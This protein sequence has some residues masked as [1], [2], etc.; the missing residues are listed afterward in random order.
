[1]FVK[2]IK[3]AERAMFPIFRMNQ[4]APNQA[5]ISVVGTGFFIKPDG[6]FITVAHVFDNPGPQTSYQF[7]GYLPTSLH[8]PSIPIVE[9]ARDNVNDIYVGRINLPTPNYMKL[10]SEL[11]AI[12]RT[13]CISGY[14]LAAITVNAQG[15]LELSGV[16]RYFQPSFVLDHGISQIP[17]GNINRNHNGFLIRDFGLFGMSGGPVFDKTGMVLGIQGSVT[18]PRV[19]TNG[20]RSITV[21]NAMAI[22]TELISELLKTNNINVSTSNWKNFFKN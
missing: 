18:A 21:E 1:M 12:G 3:K 15:G 20:T 19:S 6:T 11:P 14:P 22:K 7:M 17:A 10:S 8:S 16:R 13:I 2:A 9:I 4:I 5:Q